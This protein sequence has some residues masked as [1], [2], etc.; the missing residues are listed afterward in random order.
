[1]QAKKLHIKF[2]LATFTLIGSF[3]FANAQYSNVEFGKNRVQYKKFK[4][5][6][7]ETDNFRIYFS[8]GGQDIGKYVIQAAEKNLEHVNELLDF[9]LSNKLDIIV[10]NDISDMHQ[11]NIGIKED[12]ENISGTVQLKNNRLFVYFNGKH[13]DI[14][15]QI[16]RGIAE[17][18]INRVSGGNGIQELIKNSFLVDFPYWFAEGLA[19]YVSEDWTTEND[20]RLKQGILS[21]QFSDLS[22]LSIED[23][24][25]VGHSVWSFLEQ[26]F[27]KDVI[28]NIL[29]LAKVNR[30]VEEAFV[31]STGYSLDEFLKQWYT[32]HKDRFEKEQQNKQKVDVDESIVLKKKKKFEK[33]NAVISPDG[34]YI[35]YAANKLG[36]WKVFV[37]NIQDETTKHIK[38]GGFK[39]FNLETDLSSPI[40]AW[41]PKG[42][43]LSVVYERKDMFYIAHYDSENFKREEKPR[44][45]RKFQKIFDFAYAQDSRNIVMSAMQ[46]GQIDIYTYYLPSSRLENLT[47][48]FYDDLQPSFAK[49]GAREG[50][51]FISNRP[52]DSLIN[53]RLDTILPNRNFD[54]FFYDFNN[55]FQKLAQV[56][57]TPLANES[58]PQQFNDSSYTFLSDYTGVNNQYIGSLNSVQVGE[59]TKYIYTTTTSFGKEDS[60]IIDKGIN[61]QDAMEEGVEVKDVVSQENVPIIKTQGV[62][63]LNSNYDM[64]FSNL[65][66][67][68]LRQKKLE[69]FKAG[70]KQYFLVKDIDNAENN[71]GSNTLFMQGEL[72]KYARQ[73]SLKQNQLQTEVDTVSFK[74]I[75]REK[76]YQSKFDSWDILSAK[77]REALEINRT[78]EEEKSNIYKFTRTRQYFL[79]FMTEDVAIGLNTSTLISQYQPFQPGMPALRNPAISGMISFGITDL[80][81]NHKIYGGFSLD[82]FSNANPETPPGYVLPFKVRLFDNNQLY[83][84]YENLKGRWDKRFTYYRRNF[85]KIG[86]LS[87][88]TDAVLANLNIRTNIVE[89]KFIYPF[90]MLNSLRVGVGF[91]ND[92]NIFKSTDYIT[93]NEANSSQNWLYTKLEYVHDH[94]IEI[95][96]NIRNGF[97]FNAFVEF[98]KEFPTKEDTIAKES[99]QMPIFNNS[100]MLIWGFD[101]RHYQKVYNNIIWANRLA[102]STSVGTKKMIY[103]LGATD[104]IISPSFDE[105]TNIN[106]NNN[107]AYQSAA[108][109]MRGFMQNIRNGN[110]FLVWN[111]ELRVPIF[112][113][114]RKKPLRSNFLKNLQLIGFYDLGT[115]WEGATPFS[116]DNIAQETRQNNTGTAVARIDVYKQ[117]FVMALG[118]G[119]RIELL[120]YFIRIDYGWGYDTGKFNKA[121]LQ[122]SLGVDF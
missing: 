101:A 37:Y 104:G 109:N 6:F 27:S 115:A 43:K 15:K 60:I 90:N 92:R 79:K 45:F 114:F 78:I 93:L 72:D 67:A 100:Y 33:Y 59:R 121:R 39:T 84:T 73:Q 14:D 70:N 51:L 20:N 10:Y 46:N 98:Q 102:Y 120:G 9:K 42:K 66:L 41:E 82:F 99:V 25:F 50:V 64:S 71:N 36:R 3:F 74:N 91:R 107:Y 119:T 19:R 69:S 2:I 56:T 65:S 11:T 110:S 108:V 21:G 105:N 76:I 96:Q 111:T 117:P 118:L 83:I 94:T 52:N 34:K 30:S 23:Q 26:N 122:F 8:Q 22:K 24:A 55:P 85:N 63:Y 77:H 86:V 88:G 68:L 80:F 57:F 49:L 4:W 48:D 54:V 13:S 5:Q 95:Q 31:Y 17:L 89:T 97:R 62:N 35:A 40:L 53:Q 1:M 29:Y 47:K 44:P 87:N 58:Y 16:K 18:Y 12:V 61:L 75:N 7:Y 32:Y 38:S 112:S 103:Y 81:E 106:Y 113:A 116:N 28:G